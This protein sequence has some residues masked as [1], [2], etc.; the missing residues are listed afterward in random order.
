MNNIQKELK[1]TLYDFI[2]NLNYYSMIRNKASIVQAK[3]S[4]ESRKGQK[5]TE[6]QR[7]RMR[8][9]SKEGRRKMGKTVRVFKQQEEKLISINELDSY[10]LNR[11]LRGRTTKCRKILSEECKGKHFSPRTE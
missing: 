11:W 9:A 8:E 10:L 4:S 2:R 5:R 3:K 1:N 6:E 7:Q